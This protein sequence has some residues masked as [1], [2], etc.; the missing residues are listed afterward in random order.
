M[1]YFPHDVMDLVQPEQLD[2]LPISES[3]TAPRDYPFRR[4]MDVIELVLATAA[5]VGA[6]QLG[7]GFVTPPDSELPFGL[8][9]WFWPAMWLLATVCVPSL[10]AAAALSRRAASGPALVLTATVLLAVELLVQIPFVGL[11][12]LQLIVAL[13]GASAAAMAVVARQARKSGPS[14]GES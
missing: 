5:A 2:H 4:S 11:S 7:A 10:L 13:L 8:H 6:I 9:S 3:A 14:K 1:T 12:W